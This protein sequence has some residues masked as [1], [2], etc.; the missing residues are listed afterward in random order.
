MWKIWFSITFY[1][2]WERCL[3]TTHEIHLPRPLRVLSS[4]THPCTIQFVFGKCFH[5]EN[6]SSSEG[7]SSS[8][9]ICNAMFVYT[10]SNSF[11]PS[12]LQYHYTLLQSISED[13]GKTKKN[14]KNWEN[15]IYLSINEVHEKFFRKY[16]NNSN[17]SHSI[18]TQLPEDAAAGA[19]KE[20]EEQTDNSKLK[21]FSTLPSHSLVFSSQTPCDFPIPI[22]NFSQFIFP[23]SSFH[24]P[25]FHFPVLFFFF[26]FGNMQCKLH[27]AKGWIA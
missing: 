20:E 11:R 19:E 26:V 18:Q 25:F 22:E 10:I 5:S 17:F 9:R 3:S 6:S 7:N 2:L 21:I 8:R 4:V 24:R 16:S 15:K 13:G 12:K 1:S 23:L 14:E 27:I